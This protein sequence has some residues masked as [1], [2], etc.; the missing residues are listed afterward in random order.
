M[1][2]RPNKDAH[3]ITQDKISGSSLDSKVVISTQSPQLL[4]VLRK[5]QSETSNNVDELRY[6]FI[7]SQVEIQEGPGD[8]VE[9]EGMG[10]FEAKI[11]KAGGLRCARCW[12]YSKSVGD[13]EGHPEICERCNPIVTKAKPVE[14]I[15]A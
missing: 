8:S 9:V 4:S 15:V 5:Y 13:F 7:C 2:T 1:T 14:N 10:K 3:G 6:L 11:V 12:N